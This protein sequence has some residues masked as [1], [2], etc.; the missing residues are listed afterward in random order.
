[1]IEKFFDHPFLH[2]TLWHNTVADYGDAILYFLLALAVLYILQRLLMGRLRTYAHKTVTDI[3]D[4]VIEFIGSIKPQLY[5]VFALY[6]GVQTL[7]LNDIVHRVLTALLIIV[8]VFQATRSLQIVIEYAAKKFSSDDN[9]AH[10]KS[11]AHLLGAIVTIII[12]IFGLMMVLSNVGINIASLIAGVG[13]GGIAIAFAIKEVLADLFASF[14]IY[15]DKPFK[16]GDF[17]TAGDVSGEV[18]TIGIKTTRIKALSGEEIVISNQDLTSSRVHNYRRMNNRNVSFTI[19]VAHDTPVEKIRRIPEMIATIINDT[20]NATCK[21]AH[22]K[23][24]G[25]WGMEFSVFYTIDSREFGIYMDVNQ[26]IMFGIAEK[27]EEMDV[28]VAPKRS[29]V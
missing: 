19:T 5:V 13:I 29:L 21:R 26:K 20:D 25:D 10:T 28:A 8:V 18:K 27:L 4:L 6:I 7:Y 3:D 15:F 16:V 22:L 1:M 12:W 2:N 23:K 14:A 17:I 11:A 9:D 24:V